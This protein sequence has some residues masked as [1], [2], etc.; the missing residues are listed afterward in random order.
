MGRRELR[1][2]IFRLLF[3]IEFHKEEEMQEQIALY[4]DSLEEVPQDPDLEY[5]RKKYMDVS[6]RLEEIDGKLD[7]VTEGWSVKRMAKVDLAILRLAVYE[8]LFDE[9][10]PTGVAINEAVELCKKFGGEESPAFV[11]GV[12]AKLA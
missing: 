5:I 3:R 4:F 11:N 7:E 10:I 6:A 2:H 8:L 9:D 12:L 1:E